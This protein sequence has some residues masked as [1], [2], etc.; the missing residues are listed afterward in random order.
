MKN[1][2]LDALIDQSLKN[3]PGYGLPADFAFRIT[4]VINRRRLWKAD[5][6]EYLSIISVIVALL[7]IAGITYYYVNQ[8]AFLKMLE[9]TMQNL[10]PSILFILILNF[11]FFADRVLLPFLFNRW[12]KL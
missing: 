11:V 4:G 3:E 7:I 8:A 5:F 9:F 6:R 12:S 2:E 10:I 1:K